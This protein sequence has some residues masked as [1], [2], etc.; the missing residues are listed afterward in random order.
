MSPRR[1]RSGS[2]TSYPSVPSMNKRPRRVLFTMLDAIDRQIVHIMTIE[3]RASFRT[4]AEVTGISDQIAARRYRKLS[5][6][7]GRRVLGGVDG[8]RA[9][10]EELTR[11]PAAVPPSTA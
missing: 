6:S 11:P 8:P 1:P 3:P 4:I 5:E 9:L 7:A 10:S 2:T